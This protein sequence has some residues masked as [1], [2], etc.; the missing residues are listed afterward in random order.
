MEGASNLLGLDLHLTRE[1]MRELLRALE[2]KK[3]VID[4]LDQF[5]QES[6]GELQVRIGL[7]DAHP[8]MK[9][10]ALIGLSVSSPAGLAAKIA[11]LGPIRM[12][13]ERVMSA[14]LHIGR[15]FQYV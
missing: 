12:H 5:L 4:L 6:S 10:L 15:A 2:E 9:E 1:K 3:R 7:G 11:V 14:V 8:A 13:Y